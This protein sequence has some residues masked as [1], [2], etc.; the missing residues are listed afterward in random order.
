MNDVNDFRISKLR[1][2]LFDV[3]NTLTDNRNYQINANMLSDKIDDYS[4]DKL[5]TKSVI[6]WVTGDTY[7]T[8]TYSFR[9]KKSYSKDAIVNLKNMGFFELFEEAIEN[10]N[11]KRV[12]PNIEGIQ[13]ISCL[14]PWSMIKNDDGKTATFDIQIQIEY[15]KKRKEEL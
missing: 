8:E 4:L 12:L 13:S 6:P 7:C 14:N 5:P 3:I 15:L 10:N 9:S 11:K 2:Y 1:L